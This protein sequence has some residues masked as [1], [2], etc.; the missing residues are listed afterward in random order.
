MYH[1]VSY[2]RQVIHAS[3]CPVSYIR[4]VKHSSP[5]IIY[6]TGNTGWVKKKRGHGKVLRISR[7]PLALYAN[8]KN[9]LNQFLD[10]FQAEITKK[11]WGGIKQR[12]AIYMVFF[13]V[14]DLCGWRLPSIVGDQHFLGRPAQLQAP[15][16]IVTIHRGRSLTS[17]TP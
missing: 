12:F 6:Q 9:D 11:Y 1:P 16:G 10:N 3:P 8:Y 7:L 5:C 4:Q 17:L 13:E 14:D 15:W 2:I